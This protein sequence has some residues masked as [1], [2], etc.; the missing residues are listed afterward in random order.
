MKA[1]VIFYSPSK[2]SNLQYVMTHFFV[3]FPVNHSHH[4]HTGCYIIYSVEKVSL[5]KTLKA[6]SKN[7]NVVFLG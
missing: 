2:H 1:S 7:S 4:P 3:C 5:N 6:T